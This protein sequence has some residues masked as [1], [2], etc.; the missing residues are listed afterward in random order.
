M[1]LFDVLPNF[2]FTTSQ[3]MGDYYISTRYIGV[4]EQLKTEELKKLGNTRKTCK[5]HRMST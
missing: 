1:R 4:A 5:L 3:P 2:N